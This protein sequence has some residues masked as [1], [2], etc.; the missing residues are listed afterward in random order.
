MIRAAAVIARAGTAVACNDRLPLGQSEP[1]PA[2]QPFYT[3]PIPASFVNQATMDQFRTAVN[4]VNW[5]VNSTADVLS[6]TTAKGLSLV[7]TT[8][9]SDGLAEL[10]TCDGLRTTMGGMLLRSQLDAAPLDPSTLVGDTCEAA[11]ANA[12]FS[13][14]G[15]VQALQSQSANLVRLSL[16]PDACTSAVPAA[17]GSKMAAV[18][19]DLPREDGAAAALGADKWNRFQAYV[20]GGAAG[21]QVAFHTE[22]EAQGNV[23]VNGVERYV[24]QRAGL[25]TF[26]DTASQSSASGKSEELWVR[27]TQNG[28]VLRDSTLSRNVQVTVT[29]AP[30]QSVDEASDYKRIEGETTTRHWTVKAHAEKAATGAGQNLDV[31]VAVDGVAPKSVKLSLTPDRTGACTAKLR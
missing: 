25:G 28:A 10:D 4:G 26:T 20:E 13:F 17:E 23:T 15:I 1:P 5:N 27:E 6:L 22:T 8:P 24:Y 31:T 18:T 14:G 29:H 30:T 7:P 3:G 11:L 21:D 19:Y 12:G 9:A 16:P 2:G